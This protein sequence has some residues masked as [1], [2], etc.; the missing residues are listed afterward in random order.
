MDDDFRRAYESLI[1]K[2][3]LVINVMVGLIAA[4]DREIATVTKRLNE[5]L[6][7]M[8]GGDEA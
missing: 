8:A 2:D 6:T 5:I 4:K 7:K 1:P 3:R